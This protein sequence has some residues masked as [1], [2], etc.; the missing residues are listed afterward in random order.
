[1]KA[2]LRHINCR[3]LT[4]ESADKLTNMSS[5]IQD[6]T[7][8]AVFLQTIQGPNPAIR[9]CYLNTEV[10]LHRTSLVGSHTDIKTSKEL[11]HTKKQG[12]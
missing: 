11:S 1:M 9:F 6:T 3:N 4:R 5:R 10:R 12:N 2:P 7:C 8:F